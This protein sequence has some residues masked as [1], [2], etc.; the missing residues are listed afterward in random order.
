VWAGQPNDVVVVG[1]KGVILHFDGT[2]WTN[3]GAAGAAVTLSGVGGNGSG[4][5][6]AVGKGTILERAS[7]SSGAWVAMKP[8]IENHPLHHVWV[9]SGTTSFITGEGGVV[10]VRTSTGWTTTRTD[11]GYDL[12]GVWRQPGWGTYVVGEAGAIFRGQ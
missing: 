3:Q 12:Y 8:P 1:A 7:A 11:S 10:L 9:G 6:Y 2:S 4:L 5:V